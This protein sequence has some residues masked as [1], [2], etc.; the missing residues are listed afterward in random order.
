M[1]YEVIT[2]TLKHNELKESGYEHW[3][4]PNVAARNLYNFAVLPAGYI[5]DKGFVELTTKTRLWLEDIDVVTKKRKYVEFIYN[6]TNVL[7]RS[8]TRNNFV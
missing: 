7:F 4:A 1:L 2:L 5:S 8:S 6:N 3:K